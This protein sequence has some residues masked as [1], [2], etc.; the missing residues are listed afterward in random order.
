LYGTDFG[1]FPSSSFTFTSNLDGFFDLGAASG[2]QTGG[3][4]FDSSPVTVQD[5]PTP[6]T[7]D[8]G[9]AGPADWAAQT[10][11]LSSTNTSPGS[12]ATSPGGG[13]FGTFTS[14]TSPSAGGGGDASGSN[15]LSSSGDSAADMQNLMNLFYSANA[16]THNSVAAATS[17]THINPSQ[18]LGGSSVTTTSGG[19]GDSSSGP[20]SIGGDGDSRG[21]PGTLSSNY[22]SPA[23]SP[24]LAPTPPV[25]AAKRPIATSKASSSGR[26][27][28]E[29]GQQPSIEPPSLQRT[30]SGQQRRADPSSSPADLAVSSAVPNGPLV[31]GGGAQ[32]NKKASSSRAEKKSTPPTPGAASS[33]SAT[34]EGS[35]PPAPPPPAAARSSG[36]APTICSNCHTTNTPLW[37]RD[38][39]GNPLC[40]VRSSNLFAV[41]VSA[42]VG[43]PAR[44]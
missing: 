2:D 12:R 24:H 10:R 17:F 39:D 27:R 16:R 21:R 37:R 25:V 29:S 30:S 43:L 31:S 7:D 26:K 18:V 34:P 23:D 13:G 11:N 28:A 20:T 40:N 4:P 3:H 33:D 41:L 19:G 35:A 22:S 8:D 6:K 32:S 14:R 44:D 5:G 36:E 42:L 1:D 15:V 9:L 38:P